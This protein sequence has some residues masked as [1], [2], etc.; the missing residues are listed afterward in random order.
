MN[1]IK[2]CVEPDL[3]LADGERKII[4]V[5][6]KNGLF[7]L[8]IPVA[9]LH[10]DEKRVEFRAVDVQFNLSAAFYGDAVFAGITTGNDCNVQHEF[11]YFTANLT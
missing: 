5:N 11:S 3:S 10:Q 8:I 6:R 4:L 7:D 9:A 1:G 2:H